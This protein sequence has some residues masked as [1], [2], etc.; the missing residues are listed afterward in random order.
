[1]ILGEKKWRAKGSKTPRKEKKGKKE[2]NKCRWSVATQTPARAP[3]H[4]T[5]GG[6]PGAVHAKGRCAFRTRAQ[7][8][9]RFRREGGHEIGI[10]IRRFR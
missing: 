2:E 4:G 9:F 6:T 5:R 3:M 10:G 7:V 1:M 8:R